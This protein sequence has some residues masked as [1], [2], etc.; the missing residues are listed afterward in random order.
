MP[1][2]HI[3]RGQTATLD[4][5]EGELRVGNHATIQAINGKNVLVTGG[6]YLEGKAYVNGSLECDSI[7]SEV[8]LSKTGELNAGELHTRRKPKAWLPSPET[9]SNGPLACR[10][11][12]HAHEDGRPCGHTLRIVCQHPKK[13][14]AKDRGPGR[15]AWKPCSGNSS[16]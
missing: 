8:F 6:V 16:T 13:A 5:V 14:T 10:L 11:D 4:K 1:D 9:G 3:P 12:C 7:Q 2:L 15:N